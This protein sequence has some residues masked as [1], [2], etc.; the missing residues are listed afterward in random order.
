MRRS[1]QA[2]LWAQR[3]ATWKASGLSRRA[4]CA[5]EGLSYDTH[6][7]WTYRLDEA[8][9]Q[10]EALSRPRLLIPGFIHVPPYSRSAVSEFDSRSSPA[11]VSAAADRFA[12]R[13]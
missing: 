2:E 6:R 7:R 10:A 9:R 1:E 8:G 5:R 13:Q 3:I 4:F 12:T 11:L